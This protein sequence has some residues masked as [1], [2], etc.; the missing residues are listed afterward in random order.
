MYKEGPVFPLK[1]AFSSSNVND[2]LQRFKYMDL[3]ARKDSELLREYKNRLE[4][5]K[6]DKRSLYAVRAKLVKL[7]K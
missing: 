1:I 2:L 5:I 3:I 7:E 6:E 4:Q